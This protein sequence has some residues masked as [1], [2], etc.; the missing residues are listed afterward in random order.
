MADAIH[1]VLKISREVDLYAN[2]NFENA[3][4]FVVNIGINS[5]F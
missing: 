5:L 1:K 2:K 3:I 4:V